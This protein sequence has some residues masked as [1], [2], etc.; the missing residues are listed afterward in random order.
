MKKYNIPTS[1]FFEFNSEEYEK[2]VSY[3]KKSR[4]PLVIKADG[5]AAGKGVIIC[6]NFNEAEKTLKD[7]FVDK[8]FG[9]SGEKIIIEEFMEGEEVSILVITDGLDFVSL[10]SSQDHKRIGDNDTGKNTGGMGAYSPSPIITN[11]LLTQVEEKIIKP[12]LEGMRTEGYPFTGC[13][14]AGLMIT[15]EGPKVVEFNCRFGDPETQVILPLLKGDFLKLLYSSASGKLDKNSVR[16][17]DGC[18]VCI[19]AASKGYPDSY[20]KGFEIT[21]LD[22]ND[23][24]IIVYHAGTDQANDK[25]VSNGGRVL[26]VTAVLNKNDLREAREKAYEAIKEIHFEGM[27][28][29]KDI[30]V[31]ALKWI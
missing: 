31:K 19:V 6:S 12:T 24:K 4:Y 14:Y 3:L 10:P 9:P 8:I 16:Y 27:Y 28:Y 15:N 7:F 30:A 17:E 26:A 29:R 23:K 2:A 11:E 25:I 22:I 13:L 21:G 1:D 5:L 18:A 20:K